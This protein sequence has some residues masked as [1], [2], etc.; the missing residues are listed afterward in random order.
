MVEIEIIGITALITASMFLLTFFKRERR[1]AQHYEKQFLK[2]F[3]EMLDTIKSVRE[4]EVL[5]KKK[6]L[7]TLKKLE[8][9]N[10]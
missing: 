7:D 6:I 5:F 9:K 3:G 4:E 1:M 10:C 8:E 2:E